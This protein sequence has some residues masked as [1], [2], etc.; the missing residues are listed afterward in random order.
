M[1]SINPNYNTPDTAEICSGD[2]IFLQDNYQTAA[3]TY[4][5]SLATVKGCDSVIATTLN[6]N[7]LP[8]VALVLVEDSVCENAGAFTLGGSPSGGTYSGVGVNGGNF[9]PSLAGIGTHTITY[10]YQDGNNCTDSA[11]ATIYVDVCSGIQTATSN[12]QSIV[13]YPN[14]TSGK[15]IVAGYSR[16]LIE[17]YNV[18]GT[19]VYQSEISNSKSEINLNLPGGMYFY[20]VSNQ[21]QLIGNGKFIIR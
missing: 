3:G 2:S 20:Q 18:F 8:F 1:L 7:P 19:K 21:R 16:G 15:V 14:P 12:R 17:I 6:I 9:D 4:Y 5:D 11:T 10:T 13:I